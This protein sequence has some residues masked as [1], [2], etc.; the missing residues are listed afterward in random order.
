MRGVLAAWLLVGCYSP[1]PPAGAPCPDGV[2]PSGLVCSPLTQ[3][4]ETSAT[5]QP[6]A[7]TDAS[8]DSGSAPTYLYRRRIT[9]TNTSSTALPAQNTNRVPFATLSTLMSQSKV[10]STVNDLRIIGD[11]AGERDRVVDR[12]PTFP[13]TVINFPL[14]TSLAAGA[15]TT[16][17][18]IYYGRPTAPAAPQNPNAVF[19]LFDDFGG[20]SVSSLW[21]TNDGPTVQAGKVTLRANHT[22]AITINAATDNLPLVS[23][24]EMMVAISDPQSEPTTQPTGTFYYWFGFQRGGDFQAVPPWAVWI[25]RGKGQV[26]AE[27]SSPNGCDTSCDGP[28]VTQDAAMHYYAIERD[29][30][31]TRFYR[32]GLLSYTTVPVT[33]TDM[34]PMLRNFGATNALSAD[35]VRG[36]V[37]VTPEPTVTVGSEENL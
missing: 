32:D 34:S 17:Y 25:A 7:A 22:D 5:P 36:R 3:T 20:N 9:I 19:P 4:C 31:V 1:A 10:T 37:R 16:D 30:A 6:D 24:L 35:F 28:Y 12:T 8:V 29:S 2:C 33:N 26:H 11:V 14:A 18:A 13:A 23:S 21:L 15:T 27:Q